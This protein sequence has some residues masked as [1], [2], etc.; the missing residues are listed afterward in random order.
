MSAFGGSTTKLMSLSAGEF[1]NSIAKIGQH[2]VNNDGSRRFDL[3]GGQVDI[4]YAPQPGVRL[5][6]LLELPRA[7]VTL[8]F[9]GVNDDDRT[10]FLRTFEIAFQR[11]GG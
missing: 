8:N 10:R 11:G 5:G 2:R 9:A 4:S 3:A 1:A 7:L 6:G